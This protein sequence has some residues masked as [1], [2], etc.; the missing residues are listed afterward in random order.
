M[1]MSYRSESKNLA[2]SLTKALKNGNSEKAI[3]LEGSIG[4]LK[5]DKYKEDYEEEDD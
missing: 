2:K 4:M 5:E 3:E 1:I